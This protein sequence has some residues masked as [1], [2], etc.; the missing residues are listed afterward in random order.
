M[1]VSKKSIV[2]STAVVLSLSLIGCGG[3]DSG[4]TT[5]TTKTGVFVDAPVEG[6]NYKTATQSGYT[7][8][9]G[10]F[11]YKDGETVEFK[12][13]T[14]LLGKGKAGALVTPYTIS[15]NNTTAT[16]I[17]MVLQNFDANRSNTQVLNLSKLKD[18]IFT[19]DINL[20]AAP[21]VLQ[22]KLVTLL[23]TPS[24][25][26]HID[27][28][29]LNLITA[30]SAKNTM[31]NFIEKI[32][33][34]SE[35]NS[36]G[37]G[38]NTNGSGLQ[39]ISSEELAGYTVVSEYKNGLKALNIKKVNYI[40]LAGEKAIVVIDLFDGTRK[41]LRATIYHHDK[42]NHVVIMPGDF[43]WDNGDKITSFAPDIETENGY[44]KI[45]VGH[46]SAL[47]YKVTAI[48]SNS[49]NGIDEATVTA[50]GSSSSTQDTN[51][52]APTV[53]NPMSHNISIWNNIDQGKAFGNSNYLSE[54]T[55]HILP[56]N[57][58]VHCTDYGY[59]ASD[60]VSDFTSNLE[61][62]SMAY[63]HGQ[64]SCMESDYG[65]SGASGSESYITY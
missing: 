6:L 34:D 63:S 64:F 60:K 40:F 48:V 21:S 8:A 46:S 15:D 56:S 13:G 61:V 49:E 53:P 50:T 52:T 62:H 38:G 33:S 47:P 29:N 44:N 19:A 51:N 9:Q 37:E 42:G 58:A 35:G 31:D 11:K 12:L 26:D 39:A 23:A 57:T 41:V 7:D 27:D 59:T 20:S 45:T 36:A 65:S 1:F 22:N 2:L 30:D 54:N 14:L 16:N 18:F 32:S 43:T 55:A 4:T 28:K 5:P 25:Q 10:H 24:F 17:A 3:S